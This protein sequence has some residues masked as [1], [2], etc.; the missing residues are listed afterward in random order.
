MSILRT[1]FEQ[2]LVSAALF[3]FGSVVLKSLSFSQYAVYTNLFGIIV[4]TQ[5]LLQALVS[6]QLVFGWLSSGEIIE[7]C[8]SRTICEFNDFFIVL[9]GIPVI[10]MIAISMLFIL[11]GLFVAFRSVYYAYSRR[12]AAFL[13]LIYATTL[14]IVSLLSVR[15]KVKNSTVF[16]ILLCSSH[17]VSMMLTYYRFGLPR[18]KSQNLKRVSKFEENQILNQLCIYLSGGLVFLISERL[19]SSLTG[20]FRALLFLTYPINQL[21]SVL[22]FSLLPVLKKD[23][24][25]YWKSSKRI[26]LITFVSL[27]FILSIFYYF[28]VWALDFSEISRGML[29]LTFA[30][31]TLKLINFLLSQYLKFVG[32]WNWLILTGFI[33]GIMYLSSFI[34][35]IRYNNIA[36]LLMLS[37]ALQLSFVLVYY[38]VAAKKRS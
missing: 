35:V 10:T 20:E 7:N 4:L 36:F 29:F 15:Y 30:Y 37:I 16:I 18:I 1:A 32:S 5:G 12:G 6:E 22:N 2:S 27:P 38:R 13:S 24:D 34:W 9:Q 8:W 14:L 26:I 23:P 21:I 17:V 28:A 31:A 33:F 19:N 25:I 3:V 11:S